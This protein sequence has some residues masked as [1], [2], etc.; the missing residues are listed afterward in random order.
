[1][2]LYIVNITRIFDNSKYFVKK[3]IYFLGNTDKKAN[4]E[5]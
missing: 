1:L 3:L 4:Q 2:F 5:N